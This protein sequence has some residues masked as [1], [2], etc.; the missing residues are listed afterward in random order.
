MLSIIPA[1]HIAILMS[2]YALEYFWRAWNRREQRFMYLGKATGR[3]LLAGTYWYIEFADLMP[4]EAQILVRWSLLI[5]L[6][7][8]LI[9]VIQEHIVERLHK[10]EH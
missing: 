8:D 9:F 7:T 3:A 10:N 2:L 1:W 5:F 6:F 4:N